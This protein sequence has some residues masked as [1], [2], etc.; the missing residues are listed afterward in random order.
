MLMFSKVLVPD[1]VSFCALSPS[2]CLVDFLRFMRKDKRKRRENKG[3][4]VGKWRSNA[5]FFIMLCASFLM[6]RS[7]VFDQ[8]KYTLFQVKQLMSAIFFSKI[9]IGWSIR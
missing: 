5:S 7:H 6:H 2:L 9:L 8:T 4:R 3:K 1:C